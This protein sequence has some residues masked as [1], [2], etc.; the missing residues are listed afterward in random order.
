[1]HIYAQGDALMGVCHHMTVALSVVELEVTAPVFS[2][3]T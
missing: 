1:M 2:A 3:L